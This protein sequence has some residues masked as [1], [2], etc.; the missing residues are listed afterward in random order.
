MELDAFEQE[1]DKT[2]EILVCLG[3]PLSR[4]EV[5]TLHRLV[6]LDAYLNEEEA[7][8][9]A[10]FASLRALQPAG[11]LP[12]TLAPA[13][14]PLHV[15]FRVAGQ[16]TPAGELDAPSLEGAVLLIDA[17]ERSP[18][19]LDRPAVL[20]LVGDDGAV[21][22]SGYREPNQPLPD[23]EEMGLRALPEP[24]AAEPPPPEPTPATSGETLAEAPP[25]RARPL[26]IAGG[27]AALAAGGLYGVAYG[28][29]LRYDDPTNSDITTVAELDAYGRKT[30]ALVWTSVGLLG[31]GV[32]LGTTGMVVRSQTW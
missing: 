17:Q 32:T 8:T 20:Q 30:N 19:Y 28:M 12:S 10:A 11:A 27:V 25:P 18:L 6:G 4:R 9:L 15:I 1:R 26:L 3:E 29:S 13:G 21:L 5:A 7:R 22:W 24:P 23:F 2:F 31:V 14:N 16:M